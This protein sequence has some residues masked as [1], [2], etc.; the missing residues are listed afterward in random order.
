M[1]YIILTGYRKRI[2]NFAREDPPKRAVV[3]GK[4][5]FTP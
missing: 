4:I 5:R 1:M 2:A 3:C